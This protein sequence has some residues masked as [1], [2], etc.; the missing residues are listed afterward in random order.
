LLDFGIA[1]HGV[2]RN[3]ENVAGEEGREGGGDEI[4]GRKN[5]EY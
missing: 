3:A 2:G 5:K 1:A 4:N